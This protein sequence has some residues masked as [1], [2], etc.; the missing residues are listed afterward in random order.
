MTATPAT[1]GPCIF[2]KVLHADP[3]EE[4][5]IP[6][7]LGGTD[8]T[9]LGSGEVCRPCNGRLSRADRGLVEVLGVFR[10][11]VVENTR[12]GKHPW[13]EHEN[14]RIE[15]TAREVRFE[16]DAR[17]GPIKPFQLHLPDGETL[18]RAP[19]QLRFDARLA[20]GLHK[21]AFEL[22]CLDKGA[23]EVLQPGYDDLREYILG[24]RSGFRPF[25]VE[26]PGELDLSRLGEGHG[27][28]EITTTEPGSHVVI[29][30]LFGIRFAVG[31]SPEADLIS[32]QGR[33]W[34]RSGASAEWFA[35]DQQGLR[36]EL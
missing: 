27:H 26:K 24:T 9:V 25:L 10:P 15:R 20:R 33:E 23:S 35:F 11:Y 18:V 19:L 3:D 34:N 12:K 28:F 2:C 8:S 1:K 6:L 7:G 17:K 29:T 30:R 5:V 22:V 13:A 14:V 31:I 16:I 32:Q 21:I 36:R 4:H